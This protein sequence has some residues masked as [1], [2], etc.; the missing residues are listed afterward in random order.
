MEAKQEEQARQMAELQDHA[1]RL[2]QENDR[3]RT[4]LEANLGENTQGHTHPPPPVHLELAIGRAGPIVG[5]A[6][7]GLVFSGQNF[8]SPPALKTGLVRPNSL[9][10]AKKI[11]AGI[12]GSSHTGPSKIW[13]G[14]FLANNLMA[15]PGS[16]SRWT[17]LAHLAGPILPPLSSTK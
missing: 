15:Q 9:L 16:N 3:L 8:S 14:F 4:R 1:N 17:G 13:P 5:W 11:Q 6:K 7:I 10:K 12:A 2:Q